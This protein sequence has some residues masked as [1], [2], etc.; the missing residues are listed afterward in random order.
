V[1]AIG[2]P[3]KY[4]DRFTFQKVRTPDGKEGWLTYKDGATTYLVEAGET[5]KKA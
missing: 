4:D 3:H 5:K 1:E 2:D